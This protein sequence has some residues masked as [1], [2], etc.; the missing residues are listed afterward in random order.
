VQVG[1]QVG[2]ED[3]FY[4]YLKD[5][6]RAK[7]APFDSVAELQLVH[8]MSDELYNILKDRVTIYN[9]TA[10]I[11]LAT[12]DEVTIAIGVCGVLTQPGGCGQLLSSPLFWTALHQLKTLGGMGFAPL[13]PATLKL[14]LDAVGVA[15]DPT[16]LGQAFT[17]RT[18][19]TWYTIDAE[20][21]VGNAHR[22]IRAV[23]QSQEGQYY[24]YRIE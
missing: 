14:A 19:T 24:Y 16:K 12:A 21:S 2:D 18:S 9:T 4:A 20:G 13:T 15:Y 17:D 6:Y 5:P 3:R 8:G 23:Y 10:A 7:N 11:E 22:H 1:S